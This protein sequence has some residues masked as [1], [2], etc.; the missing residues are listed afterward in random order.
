MSTNNS[1]NVSCPSSSVAAADVVEQCGV[2]PPRGA[3]TTFAY[4]LRSRTLLS[5]RRSA[6]A[7]APFG[8][9][10]ELVDH[11]QGGSAVACR[12]GGIP[13][14]GV[15]VSGG[16]QHVDDPALAHTVDAAEA[17][18][19]GDRDRVGQTAGLDDDG[20]EAQLGIGEA[21]QRDVESA[22][23]GQA[24]DAPTGDRRGLVH[25][26]GHQ[27]GIDVQFA[28]IVDHDADPCPGAP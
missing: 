25:L 14:D 17:D 18:D 6:A 27:P 2:D 12:R 24:A 11:H 28:E 7:R 23:V 13:V 1:R 8:D 19:P 22:L 16:V 15:E 4:G 10:V 9:L 26:S 3:P 20:V 5:M 21:G